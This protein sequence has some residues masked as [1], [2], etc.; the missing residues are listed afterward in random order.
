MKKMAPSRFWSVEIKEVGRAQREEINGPTVDSLVT[1]N[2][3]PTAVWLWG[4]A[5]PCQLLSC[6]VP[7]IHSN[8]SVVNASN[9]VGSIPPLPS[10]LS[11]EMI[12]A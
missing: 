12:R 9:H 5:Q 10:R 2:T 1:L 7:L 8:N 6:R 4:T 11:K 3:Y